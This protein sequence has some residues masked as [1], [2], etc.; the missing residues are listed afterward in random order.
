MTYTPHWPLRALMSVSFTVT[1]CLLYHKALVSV[2]EMLDAFGSINDREAIML[3]ATLI[4][5]CMVFA[6]AICISYMFDM[7]LTAIIIL[8]L[9]IWIATPIISN[10]Y[11]D[12][13]PLS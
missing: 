7:H 1:I 9:A 3:I 12:T 13:S 8:A 4:A 11:L 6:C 10:F 5:T 2:S